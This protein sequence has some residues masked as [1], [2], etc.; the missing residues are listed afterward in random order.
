MSIDEQIESA[1]IGFLS[2]RQEGHWVRE[3]FEAGYRAALRSVWKE[4]PYDELEHGCVYHCLVLSGWRELKWLS[5]MQWWDSFE[6]KEYG[7]KDVKKVLNYVGA[8]DPA[9]LFG[10]E[11]LK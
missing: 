10:E 4:V 6:K 8:I 3:S 2:S 9:D 7:M 11:T 5:G 1:W